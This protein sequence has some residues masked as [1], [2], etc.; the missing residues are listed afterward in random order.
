MAPYSGQDTISPSVSITS[1]EN[2]LYL[3]NLRL[4]SRLFRQRTILFGDITVNVVASDAQ[5]GVQKVEFY[6]DDVLNPESVDTTAP[7]SWTWSKGSLLKH[8]Y[9]II[10]VAYDNA[11]NYNVDMIDVVR[12]F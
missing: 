5:S 12:F 10:V 1:P 6:L 4:F 11:E 3:R 9:T 7:Y 8:R 2:G